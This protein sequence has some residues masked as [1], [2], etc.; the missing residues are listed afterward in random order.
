MKASFVAD[1]LRGLHEDSKWIFATE[2][3]LMTGA[4]PKNFDSAWGQ[5]RIDAFALALWPSLEFE[6]VAYEIK[7]SR[8][9]WMAELESPQKRAAAMYLSHRFY[10]ALAR[11]IFQREDFMQG[12]FPWCGVIE[13]DESGAVSVIEKARRREAWPMP[14]PFI[15]SFLRR[16]RGISVPEQLTLEEV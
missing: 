14:E 3:P 6:R 9:D 1:A 8:A 12:V 13:V 11:G 16:V 2:I 4:Y 7:V 10:F 5:R 15:A